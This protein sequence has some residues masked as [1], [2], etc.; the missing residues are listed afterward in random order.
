MRTGMPRA[1]RQ[2]TYL[3]N[4][5]NSVNLVL[6]D[7]LSSRLLFAPLG[8]EQSLFEVNLH[9]NGSLH[10]QWQRI[11]AGAAGEPSDA[12]THLVLS[13]DIILF[14]GQQSLTA[15]SLV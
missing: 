15:D 7:L 12:Q 1:A 8:S 3:A 10:G 11:W 5:V 13:Q 6:L 9:E 2:P 14:R 4:S